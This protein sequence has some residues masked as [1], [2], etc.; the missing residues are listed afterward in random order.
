M[1]LNVNEILDAARVEIE[2]MLA[3][4]KRQILEASL[5]HVDGVIPV[6]QA[7]AEEIR[8]GKT[9]DGKQLLVTRFATRE[10]LRNIHRG[11][12]GE[13]GDPGP[14]GVS[15]IPGPI[16][17]KGDKGDPGESIVGPVGPKGDKGDPGRDG[18]SIIGPKGDP[19]EV[20]VG[21]KG[22]KG[23]KGD[24]GDSI[25]GPPGRD[26]KSVVGPKGDKGDPGD[27]IVG[28]QGPK[29][30][31]GD[32]GDSIVG[33]QGPKGDKGESII[34]PVGLKGD[35]GDPGKDGLSR[36]DVENAVM[37][38]LKDSGLVY[39]ATLSALK[40]AIDKIEENADPRIKHMI[41]RTT[42]PLKDI[43]D[44]SSV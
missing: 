8:T 34:G 43:L 28:P 29:G 39:A 44:K 15:N 22:D 37:E 10:E 7:T 4:A 17:P 33:P 31:K 40:K 14:A 12:K 2:L 36:V 20:I 26:G 42:K 32:P 11:D 27:S 38:V 19:G 5:T 6:R 41:L 30:D 18:R 23:D 16:G 9:H 24:P 25:I 21:P 35:K 13:K 1:D 3:D